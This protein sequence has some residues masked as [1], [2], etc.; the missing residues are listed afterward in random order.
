MQARKFLF[1]THALA[2]GGAERV[3]AILASEFA[4]RGHETLFAVDFDAPENRD[5]LD[6]RVRLVTLPAGHPRAVIALARLMRAERPEVSFS[7][8]G[9]SNLKHMLASLL[10]G[11]QRRAILSYHGFFA[12]EPQF[13]SRLGNRLTPLLTRLC[14]RAVAVSDG[15]RAALVDAHGAS[16]AR[17]VRIYNPVDALDPPEGLS[18]AALAARP[19][20]VLFVGRMAPDKDLGTLLAAFARL[21]HPEARLEIVGDGP[22]RP[23][24]EAEAARLGLGGRV[25]FL[26]YQ[27]NPGPAYRGARVF[28]LASRRE[29]F[30]N[31]VAEALAH[32]LAVVSTASAGPSEIL[33]G[34]RFGAL[35]PIGDAPAL[36]R[37]L[38]SALAD[39][40]DPAPRM[41]RAADF[42]VARAADAYLALAE[43]VIAEAEGAPGASCGAEDAG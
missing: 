32:G 13:L 17:T 3:F 8:I 43:T 30:G 26:G 24:F 39:P 6:P 16:P 35:V 12:S 7:G 33:A 11:R 5:F 27:R 38:D 2:G 14:G 34:G 1:Y 15:L 29:S 19:P 22:E 28:A 40:G 25:R 20:V 4:R 31:V 18:R 21:T 41:V 9:V 37:A 36:A 23:H 42:T 10:A